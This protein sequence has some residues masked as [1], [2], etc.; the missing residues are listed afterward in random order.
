MEQ[1]TLTNHP[2][3][4]LLEPRAL[5]PRVGDTFQVVCPS[6][7]EAI[8]LLQS[9]L[10]S[11]LVAIDFETRGTDY[12]LSYAFFDES[13]I[14]GVG[15]AWDTGSCYLDPVALGPEA[16]SLLADLMVE[17]TGL[18][19]HNVYFDGGWIRRDL[20]QHAQWYACTYGMY[21]QLANEGW[22]GQRWGL[23]NAMTDLLM[24]Q[25]TNEHELDNWLIEN[26]YKKHNG[27]AEKGEMWRA[28]A[29]IL[30]QYCVLDAEATYLLMVEVFEPVLAHFPKVL[31]YHQELFLPHVM[32][33]IDQK[34][35]GIATDREQWLSHKDYLDKEIAE[36]AESFL[37]HGEVQPHIYEWELAKYNEYLDKE[38]PR[39][40]KMIE[41]KEPAKFLKDGTTL[42]KNWV[43]WVALSRKLPAESK[44][45]QNWEQRRQLIDAGLEEDFLFNVQSGDH[46]RWLLY[47][48]LGMRVLLETDSGMPAVSED[49]LKAMGDIGR[50]LIDR[51]LRTKEVSYLTDYIERTTTRRTVHPSFRLPGTVT[52]RLSGK[53]PNLQQMPKTKGTLSGFVSRPGHSFVDCDVNALEM[54][55]TAELSQD[56][57]LLAL[58]G[59]AAKKNDIY[60]FYGALMPGLGEKIV[61][62]GYDRLNPTAETIDAAKKACKKERGIAKLLILSDNYGSG[63]KK[64]HKILS[65]EG[66]DMPLS[67]VEAMH[68]ALQEAKAGVTHYSDW[69]RNEWRSNGGWVENG[70]G[71]PM[72]VDEKYTKDLLNRVVQSTGHDILMM[73]TKIVARLL[74]EARVTWSPIVMDFH[75]ESIIEVPDDQVS[76][77]TRIM[78]KDAYAELNRQ[79]GGTCPLK[80]TA[81]V[82]KT[83]AGIKLEE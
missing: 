66:I 82:S 26:G 75:D 36:L 41:R 59:P 11:R 81:A 65:L 15:L 22:E 33:H 16:Y 43:K 24:W 31:S 61:A 76:L 72:C 1:V 62:A 3:F 68:L 60:L 17:H 47:G 48:K 2:R 12:S 29:H 45:W 13:H 67:Q 49:A 38:P 28:P 52:G 44:N 69:L 8:A 50:L 21:M 18:L 37:T 73:Y 64:K 57:N 71:R 34:I 58:Y 77:A 6:D 27:K 78:E 83:L 42:S 7:E 5:P 40:K 74:D 20:G 55:V 4:V 25:D 56:D 10:R 54:V 14:V 30:G 51:S 35:R 46:L 80:G 23:K 53:E 63:V 70:Y 32:V 9:A 19:A 79:L 39:Y